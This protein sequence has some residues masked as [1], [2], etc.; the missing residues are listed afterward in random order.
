MAT[1][2]GILG[3]MLIGSS[4]LLDRALTPFLDFFRAVPPPALVPA[5]GLLLG[6]T[7]LSSVTIVVLAIVW[8]ILLNTV[9]G[10]RTIPAVRKEM[11]RTLGLTPVERLTKVIFPSLGP[12]IMTG[13]R[14][15]VSMS[16][17]VTLV[18][19]IIGTGRGLGRLLV[20]QQQFF[21]SASVWGLL[22]VIGAFGY[23][24]NV[25]FGLFETAIFSRWPEGARP[26]G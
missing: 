17:I 11:A 24:I 8:P 20:D 13:L 6:P 9:T 1:V 4:N 2:L 3:G 26:V 10:I 14:I 5:L 21:E 15:S 16:L 25:L 12:N 22:V 23:L 7:L 19:D 18:T